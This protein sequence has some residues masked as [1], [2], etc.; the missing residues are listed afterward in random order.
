MSNE[1]FFCGGLGDLICTLCCLPEKPKKICLASKAAGI[2]AELCN[3]LSIDCRIIDS[4]RGYYSQSECE[5]YHGKLHMEDI[6]QAAIY[7]KIL[8]GGIT[9]KRS[10]IFDLRLPNLMN[11]EYTLIVP[12]SHGAPPLRNLQYQ[13]LE[14]AYKNTTGKI[15]VSGWGAFPVPESNRV[16]NLMGRTNINESISLVLHAKY[17]FCVDT[18]QSCL[19]SQMDIPV[20]IKSRNEF[21]YMHAKVFNAMAKPNVKI[22]HFFV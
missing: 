6:S 18:W 17:I 22:C 9:F 11:C 16:L 19:A 10:E 20:W 13:D 1:H 3:L 8:S 14:F 15:V 7:P 21:Y 2:C 5:P 12:N 4:Q